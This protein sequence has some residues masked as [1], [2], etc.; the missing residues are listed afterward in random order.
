IRWSQLRLGCEMNREKVV[1]FIYLVTIST[2]SVVILS[3]AV[4]MLAGLFNEKV[5]N[6]QIFEM[7]GPA[8]NTIVGAFV[9]LLGGLSLN[10][11]ENK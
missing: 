3:V 2:L 11:K 10:A 9:G 4:V 6:A 1:D 8:F 7:L 5:D